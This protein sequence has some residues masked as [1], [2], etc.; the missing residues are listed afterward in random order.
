MVDGIV[1]DR[2]ARRGMSDGDLPNVVGRS[3][4]VILEHIWSFCDLFKLASTFFDS[5]A[6]I[7]N[8][9]NSSVGGCSAADFFCD[10]AMMSMVFHGSCEV[11][12]IEK[13]CPVFGSV[14]NDVDIVLSK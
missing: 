10:F 4:I 12:L 8:I 7:S 6:S 13:R 9:A 3:S 14:G 1:L 5:P 11:E 2:R